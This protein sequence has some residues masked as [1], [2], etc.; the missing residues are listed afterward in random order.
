MLMSNSIHPMFAL[1]F[2]I[3]LFWAFSASTVFAEQIIEG[4]S[5]VRGKDFAFE[6]KA[7][8]RWVLDNEAAKDQGLNLVFYPTGTDWEDSKAVLYIRVRSNEP[9]IRNIEDQVND[10]LSNLRNSGSPNATAKYLKTV[11]TQDASK[12][13]IYYFTGDKFG[14]FEATAYIQA[15]GSIHFITLS[16]R[17]QDSFRQALPAFHSIVTSYKD[18][19][20]PPTM[21]REPADDRFPQT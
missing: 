18:L 4:Y 19:T 12:A 15:K 10:T 3:L 16:A 17:D 2:T 6:I 9:A 13:Q 11:T 14:N 20:K 1:R 21:Q 5:V 8:R 7:P